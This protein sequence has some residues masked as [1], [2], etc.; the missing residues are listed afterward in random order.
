MNCTKAKQLKLH[1][2]FDGKR[3][4]HFNMTSSR[5]VDL[6]F[7]W[8]KLLFNNIG[9]RNKQLCPHHFSLSLHP[10]L[11]YGYISQIQAPKSDFK[12]SKMIETEFGKTLNGLQTILKLVQIIYIQ[13]LLWMQFFTLC[14]RRMIC[15][16][17]RLS[18][19]ICTNTTKVQKMHANVEFFRHFIA[20]SS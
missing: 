18:L 3:N 2:L 9:D 1:L 14:I 8:F 12:V 10:S 13:F 16:C 7:K 17:I 11:Y 19:Q 6:Y 15:I 20:S 4:F 5:M